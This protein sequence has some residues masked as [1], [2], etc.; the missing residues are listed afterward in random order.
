M[1]PELLGMGDEKGGSSVGGAE[2]AVVAVSVQSRVWPFLSELS[3]LVSYP[4]PYQGLLQ[5][6][7]IF[8]FCSEFCLLI[9]EVSFFTLDLESLQRWFPC[10]F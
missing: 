1:G 5:S 7:F 3:S 6:P 10:S 9:L 2:L 8:T 4:R